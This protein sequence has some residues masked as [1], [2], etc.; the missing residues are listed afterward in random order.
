M[1]DTEQTKDGII[2]KQVYFDNEKL[3]D[4]KEL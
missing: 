3:G 4:E 1:K 2:N